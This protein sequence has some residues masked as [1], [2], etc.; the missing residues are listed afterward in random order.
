MATR[1]HALRN[2]AVDAGFG[3]RLGFGNRADLHE[4]LTALAVRVADIGGGIAPEEHDQ[5]RRLVEAGFDLPLLQARQNDIDPERLVG[6]RARLADAR[7]N[8][9]A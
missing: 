9:G 2:D 5:R 4:D 1:L 8:L 6:Q 7:V 3:R